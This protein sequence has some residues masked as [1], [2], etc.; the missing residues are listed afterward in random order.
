MN[1]EIDIFVPNNI[2]EQD[3]GLIAATYQLIWRDS[4]APQEISGFTT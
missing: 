3:D 2:L 4:Q 1:V